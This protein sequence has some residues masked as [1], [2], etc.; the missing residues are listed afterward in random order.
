MRDF[1]ALS[2]ALIGCVSDGDSESIFRDSTAIRLVFLLLVAIL[3][4]VRFA[5]CD[6]VPLRHLHLHLHP[7]TVL[8]LISKTYT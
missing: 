5:I 7:V 2:S 1:G 8:E 6:S 4:I 3:G